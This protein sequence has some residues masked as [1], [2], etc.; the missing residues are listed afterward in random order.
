M[1]DNQEKLYEAFGELLY[2]VAMADG[3]IQEEEI[4]TLE[5]V[6]LNH[7]WAT[8]IKW[9]F[10]Y[11]RR[12]SSAIE[13]VYAKVLDYCKFRGPH[14]EYQQMIAVMQAVAEASSGVD[15]DEQNIID[16]FIFTLTNQFK[17]DI[18]QLQ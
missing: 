15:E 12:N 6:L 9:S 1:Q 16:G 11:E 17:K 10:D 3:M 18:E 8:S 13:E 14:P 7:P 4:E 5:N 2:V